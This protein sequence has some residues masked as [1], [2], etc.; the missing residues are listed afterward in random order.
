MAL[1]S[2]AYAD[3]LDRV[4]VRPVGLL[5]TDDNVALEVEIWTITSPPE[6]VE[7]TE[8]QINGSEVIVDIFADGGPIDSIGLL[9]ETVELGMLPADTY[10]YQIHQHPTGDC[11]EQT[12]S[13]SFCIQDAACAAPACACPE[14]VRPQYTIIDI[15]T[16]GG[17]S[18]NA[19]AINEG[20]QLAGSADTSSGGRH[21][22]IWDA[23]DMTDLGTLQ[24]DPVSEAWDISDAGHVVGI[25][26]NASVTIPRGFI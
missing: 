21:A 16:L 2:Q 24:D 9:Y 15:G 25:S 12:L 4:V 8:V 26:A 6:L 1:C 19:L 10:T 5:T 11:T 18:A 23:G 13:G 7:P 17:L 22:Y 20:G 3:C 14:P